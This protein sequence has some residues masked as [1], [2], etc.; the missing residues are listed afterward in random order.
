MADFP[1]MATKDACEAALL[2]LAQR[3]DGVPDS[4][5]RR[6]AV[7]RTIS[8]HLPDLQVTYS[9]RLSDGVLSDIAEEQLPN[10]Q[11]RLTVSSDDLLAVTSG[12]LSFTNA[13]SSGR[14]RI[15][16]SMLDMLRLRAVL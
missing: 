11:I 15:E 2:E 6:H 7:D 8:C 3:L 5:K 1:A 12:S 4:A 9:G 16:A 10:A 14:L 13:W